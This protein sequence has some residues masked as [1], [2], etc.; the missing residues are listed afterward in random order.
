MTVGQLIQRLKK[1]DPDMPVVVKPKGKSLQD[2]FTE[3][4]LS[5]IVELKVKEVFKNPYWGTQL[6]D[7]SEG[8]REK[9]IKVLSLAGGT[10]FQRG[11]DE[12]AD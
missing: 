3:L 12:K 11:S 8:F 7:A 5:D 9:P 6:Y 1:F 10:W 4:K 2:D